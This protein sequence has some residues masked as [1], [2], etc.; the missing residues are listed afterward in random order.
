MHEQIRKNF[1]YFVVNMCHP[2]VPRVKNLFINYTVC[3]HVHVPYTCTH[4]YYAWTVYCHY[5]IATCVKLLIVTVIALCY[6]V[7]VGEGR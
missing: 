6:L 2:P 3:I 1:C 7:L 4:R 5:P